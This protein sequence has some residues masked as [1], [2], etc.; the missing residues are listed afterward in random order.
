MFISSFT[1]YR[2]R[3]DKIKTARTY[4]RPLPPTVQQPRWIPGILRTIYPRSS[5][6]TTFTMLHCNDRK[7]I[8]LVG[9][10]LLKVQTRQ[11]PGFRESR[12]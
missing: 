11:R 2:Y 9:K 5:S 12:P 8:S 10:S 3:N 7:R 1:K 4:P 6:R